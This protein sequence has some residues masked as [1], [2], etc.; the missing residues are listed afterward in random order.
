MK[1][2]LVFCLTLILVS[3]IGLTAFAIDGA[4]VSSSELN[5]A[6]TLISVVPT[7][8]NTNIVNSGNTVVIVPYG[9]RNTLNDQL[10]ANMDKA[11]S[12]IVSNKDLTKLNWNLVDIAAKNQVSGTNL[13]VS[14]L[15]DLHIKNDDGT[16]VLSNGQTYNI[17]LSNETAKNFVCLMKLNNSGSWEIVKDAKLLNNNLS[18][19]F[20][21]AAP[22]AVVVNNTVSTSSPK[23]GDYDFNALAIMTALSAL[24]FLGLALTS[25]KQ[26]D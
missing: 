14:N 2:L 3:V 21:Y 4:F 20:D 11:Y 6:P 7:G 17:L 8:S 13:A 25:K 10:K 23:T 16:I 26:I 22:Y 15:F 5:Q 1:K 12:D 18:F 9:L 19:T 24:A